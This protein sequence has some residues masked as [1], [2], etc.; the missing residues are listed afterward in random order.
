MS[1]AAAYLQANSILS[2]DI[3]IDALNILRKNIQ[4]LE[5]DF[6]ISPIRAEINNFNLS[7]QIFSKSLNTTTIMNPPFGVQKKKAD[8]IFLEK[9]FTFS[10]IVYSIHLSSQSV[11]NFIRNY[12]KKYNWKIDYIFPYQ[13]E[14]EKTYAFHNFS[15]KKID[16][17]I[18]RFRK[19]NG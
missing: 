2:V 8:R 1:I 12:I 16:V 3:D 15:S 6:I 10:D 17:D 11:Q 13:L 9:A 18:Y 5:L 4:K 7:T 19:K 14:L